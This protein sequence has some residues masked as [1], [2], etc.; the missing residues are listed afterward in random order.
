MTLNDVTVHMNDLETPYFSEDFENGFSNGWV[1]SDSNPW[2]LGPSF[3][4]GP[5]SATSGVSA[6]Y[7]DDYYYSTGSIGSIT[8]E[9]I[10]LY[11]ST[12]PELRF[13]YWDS[14]DATLYRF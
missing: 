5:G 8:T 11:G 13:Q 7:F 4:A 1:N 10:N 14:G 6:A 9:E 3:S 2:Q 12:A